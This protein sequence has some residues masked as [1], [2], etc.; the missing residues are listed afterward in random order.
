MK[1]TVELNTTHPNVETGKSELLMMAMHRNQ[2][3]HKDTVIKIGERP[4]FFVSLDDLIDAVAILK[5]E[6]ELHDNG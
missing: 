3:Q 1:T 6:K 4:E 5:F 2:W